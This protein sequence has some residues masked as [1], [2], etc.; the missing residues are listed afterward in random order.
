MEIIIPVTGKVGN[1]VLGNTGGGN[2]D[3]DGLLDADLPEASMLL[4]LLLPAK[5]DPADCLMA[6]GCGQPWPPF[7]APWPW[8]RL[9]R[10]VTNSV[11]RLRNRC[12]K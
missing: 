5:F 12:C 9:F 1:E 7:A 4:L 3:F 8:F 2:V 10:S 6:A 11:L